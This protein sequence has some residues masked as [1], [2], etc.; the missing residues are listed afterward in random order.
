MEMSNLAASQ[1][2]QPASSSQSADAAP[3]KQ[4]PIAPAPV[5]SE[6]T[7][8]TSKTEE[9][10]SP[11]P[12]PV[13]KA[14]DAPPASKAP[15]LSRMETEAIGPSSENPVVKADPSAGPTVLITLLLTSGARH[16][17]KIDE[18]YLRKRGITVEGMDPYLISVYTLKE[19]I[20]RDWREGMRAPRPPCFSLC[21]CV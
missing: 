14:A 2:Q 1:P 6:T 18:R 20:W 12:P 4:D 11:Q 21:R 9:I 3:Q 8:A 19:L 17:Y 13:E 16:P 7:P 5:A 15:P 10:D